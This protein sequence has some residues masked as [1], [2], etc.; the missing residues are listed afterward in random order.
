M[1]IPSLRLGTRASALARWQAQ[2]VADELAARGLLVELVPIT[3]RGDASSENKIAELGGTGLFTKE[4]QRALLDGKIDL[5]VHSLKDLPTESTPN[6]CLAAVPRRAS[7]FDALISREGKTLYELPQ[8]AVIGTGSARRRSQL[9][10][11]RRDL[12][13]RDVRG[14]V[15][16]RLQK[17]M[18]GDYDALILA[19]AGLARLG[20]TDRISEV[21]A[22]E[23][24]LPA[25]GQGALAIET[26]RE[27]RNTIEAVE[28]LDDA[29]SHCSVLAERALLIGLG[30][31][32]LAPVGGWARLEHD[33]SLRLDA[34]VL[35]PEGSVRLSETL[36]GDPERPEPLG[37][38]VAQRLLA[39]GAGKL[40]AAA[41]PAG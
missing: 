9:L 36:A 17:L 22:P 34:V 11:A 37:T 26:R 33:G 30:G 39:R 24:M 4:L 5:A 28:G 21:L 8:G 20:Q 41:R 18:A 2:W 27:D 12:T 16:T 6:L 40:I 23:V 19:E 10:F 31:G 13:M 32:C 29:E 38:E 25:V 7:P 3:T 35:P 15:D 1:S 14:N